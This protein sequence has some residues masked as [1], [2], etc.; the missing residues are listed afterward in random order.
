MSQFAPF[1]LY[2]VATTFTPGPN[3]I[4][5][6]TLAMRHGLRG[7]LRFLAGIFV[8]FV[9]LMF[10][11][12]LLNLAVAGLAPAVKGWLNLLGAAYMLYLAYHILRSK[13]SAPDQ[14]EQGALNSFW[15]GVAMQFLNVK[16]ILFGVTVYAM[17]ITSVYRSVAAVA[18]FAVLLAICTLLAVSSWALGGNLFR[19]SYQRHYKIFNLIMGGLLVYTAAASLMG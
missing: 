15:A 16:A 9:V 4:M 6:M 11:S 5:T 17:F 1:L 3:T 7:T 13:P 14:A 12:G 18:G 10:L 19:A 8:G 2:V